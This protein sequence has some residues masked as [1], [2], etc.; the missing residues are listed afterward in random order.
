MSL[1]DPLLNFRVKPPIKDSLQVH[2]GRI[3]T[4]LGPLMRDWMTERLVMELA[5]RTFRT[6]GLIELQRRLTQPTPVCTYRHDN[7]DGRERE[8]PTEANIV[9]HGAAG[10]LR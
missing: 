4:K 1:P 5:L 8:E 7:A 10:V 2:A 6:V 3:G 9:L